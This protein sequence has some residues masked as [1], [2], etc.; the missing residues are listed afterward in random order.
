[1]ATS[2]AAVSAVTLSAPAKPWY[3]PMRFATHVLLTV[4]QELEMS[5]PA[6]ARR[7]TIAPEV[8]PFG[9]LES[10]TLEAPGA[11]P[12]FAYRLTV[13]KV[14]GMR[15]SVWVS[16]GTEVFMTNYELSVDYDASHVDIKTA[17]E[18]TE[19][20]MRFRMIA[21]A[22]VLNLTFEFT[23]EPPS[24]VRVIYRGAN[25]VSRVMQRGEV[26]DILE[27]RGPVP[28]ILRPLT[29]AQRHRRAVT[30]V[31]ELERATA[32]ADAAAE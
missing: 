30:A 22:G 29:R 12:A 24:A 4:Q 16:A 10:V 28:F 2:A 1:M 7:V 25:V 14:S 19:H 8:L 26:A 6:G 11:V 17:K 9:L 23:A 3:K 21:A 20:D 5:V 18:K 15:D 31:T 27:K 13:H 32:S